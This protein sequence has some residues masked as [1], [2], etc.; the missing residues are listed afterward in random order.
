[1]YSQ[2]PLRRHKLTVL[3]YLIV[4]ELLQINHQSR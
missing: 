3:V 4:K 1:V 2:V